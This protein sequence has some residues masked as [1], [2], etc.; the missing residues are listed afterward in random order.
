MKKYFFG[1]VMLIIIFCLAAP[2]VVC[3]EGE[4]S[5]TAQNASQTVEKKIEQGGQKLEAATTKATGKIEPKVRE[6]EV[7]TTKA[8]KCA[9][10]KAMK[11]ATWLRKKAARLQA[12]AERIET[13]VNAAILKE[14]ERLDE[15]VRTL[16]KE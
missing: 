14:K 2:S 15:K 12:E 1:M 3:S 6:A 16:E 7:K 13:R 5:K 11:R 10:E 9:H 4:A 8:I